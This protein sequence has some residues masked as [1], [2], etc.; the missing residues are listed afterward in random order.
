[1][2]RFA[3]AFCRLFRIRNVA[4]AYAAGDRRARAEK[5]HRQIRTFC[6]RRDDDF[7]VCGPDVDAA[8]DFAHCYLLYST[9]AAR[10]EKGK[11]NR[12]QDALEHRSS[13]LLHSP[14]VFQTC[15]VEACVDEEENDAFA[16]RHLETSGLTRC[17][18]NI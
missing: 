2:Q 11:V 4:V 14:S 6:W 17:R 15:K 1:M 16:E 9:G 13:H 8:V 10:S 5:L 7:D 18:E 3:D 12:S